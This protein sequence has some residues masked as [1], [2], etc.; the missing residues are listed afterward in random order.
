MS[1]NLTEIG[2]CC[3]QQPPATLFL[4]PL[5]LRWQ[6]VRVGGFSRKAQTA[7][8]LQPKICRPGQEGAL[9]Y[10]VFRALVSPGLEPFSPLNP[11]TPRF[12]RSNLI[13]LPFA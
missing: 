7:C 1:F 6:G 10:G 3:I 12:S 4:K 9:T 8:R 11:S 13:C 5:S 2:S